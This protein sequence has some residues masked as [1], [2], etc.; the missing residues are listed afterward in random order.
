MNA[1]SIVVVNRQESASKL[2][3][4]HTAILYKSSTQNAPEPRKIPEQIPQRHGAG[5]VARL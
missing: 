2:A 3:T 5:S 4:N 1:V